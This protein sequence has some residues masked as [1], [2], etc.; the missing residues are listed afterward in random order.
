MDFLLVL[1][2]V[3]LP[4]LHYINRIPLM[5]WQQHSHLK[6][7]FDNYVYLIDRKQPS[8]TL[9]CDK[10]TVKQHTVLEVKIRYKSHTYIYQAKVNTKKADYSQAR[11]NSRQC[12]E[13]TYFRNMFPS[14][15]FHFCTIR[16]A[17]TR[18]CSY[19]TTGHLLI[20][21]NHVLQ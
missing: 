19:R 2:A 8:N 9:K 1:N 10:D 16:T 12:Q 6:I 11:T 7:A 4:F 3:D 14:S 5:I 13:S 20:P 18:K 15:A 21:E 17:W